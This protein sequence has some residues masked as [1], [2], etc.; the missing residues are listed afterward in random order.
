[1]LQ[2]QRDWYIG[3]IGIVL[4]LT[5]YSFVTLQKAITKTRENL[6][7]RKKSRE[8]FDSKMI[9]RGKVD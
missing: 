9:Y 8:V 3:V 5:L 7:L 1:M 6:L 2:A 4:N